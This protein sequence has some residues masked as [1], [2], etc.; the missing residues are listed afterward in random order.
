MDTRLAYIVNLVFL[1]N[2]CCGRTAGAQAP[3]TLLPRAARVRRCLQ[4]STALVVVLQNDFMSLDFTNTAPIQHPSSCSSHIRSSSTMFVH[5]RI[6]PGFSLN[7][8]SVTLLKT[9]LF[10]QCHFVVVY[11]SADSSATSNT[12]TQ[13]GSCSLY[14]FRALLHLHVLG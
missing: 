5:C 6:S 4:S 12:T 9:S 14:L 3:H 1:L 2:T 11:H 8:N 10:L 7:P 13:C